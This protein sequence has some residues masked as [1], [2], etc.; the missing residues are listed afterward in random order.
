MNNDERYVLGAMLKH[1]DMNNAKFVKSLSMLKPEHF[2]T[3][4]GSNVFMAI[5]S[6]VANGD[7]PDPIT[8]EPFLAGIHCDEYE[9]WTPILVE[10][11]RGST[12][13]V[14]IGTHSQRI[15]ANYDA[16][17]A[18]L[19]FNNALQ[20][21]NDT[22]SD[23]NP[24]NRIKNA[25]AAVSSIDI[26]DES[27]KTA[28]TMKEILSGVVEDM[29]MMIKK[30]GGLYGLS[31]GFK[32]LDDSLDGLQPGE[33]YA[34]V[35]CPGSGKTTFALNILTNAVLSG[36]K[37]LFYSLEM[38]HKQIGVKLLSYKS[39]VEQHLIK[40]GDLTSRQETKVK[41]DAAFAQMMDKNL[42][43]DEGI[44]LT[45]ENLDITTR[46]H[47]M[48]MGGIDII[49][50]DYL[51]LMNSEGESETVKASNAAKACKRIAKKYNCPVII[52][53][54]P[55]KNVD[56]RLKKSDIKQTGQIEQDAAA[57]MLLY[58]DNDS[59]IVE[60]NIAKNRFG[61]EGVHNF[62]AQF[63]TNKFEWTGEQIPEP[64]EEKS[65][66]N[67]PKGMAYKQGAEH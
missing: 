49:G 14:N 1:W 66:A 32:A 5:R 53:A 38:P 21:L 29:E 15:K 46:K 42:I 56:G 6:V 7:I 12:S 60:V 41:F 55:V 64:K 30:G 23:P 27:N 40:N 22:M 67:R 65:Q 26:D 44:N 45:A 61:S 59:G 13:A 31:T 54:Q 25:L 43:V 52:L 4:T 34:V 47:E 51:T 33:V 62:K 39:G 57:I 63:A 48:Q 11:F 35:G 9:R 3:E 8:A 19:L 20:I 17:H 18:G 10:L 28:Y 37:G 50:V 2:T 58:K 24:R 36:S 16:K